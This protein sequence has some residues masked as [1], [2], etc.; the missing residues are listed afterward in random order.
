MN[1]LENEL[2]LSISKVNKDVFRSISIVQ[3]RKGD[4]FKLDK[5]SLPSKHFLFCE[6]KTEAEVEH[7]INGNT[8]K[9]SNAEAVFAQITRISNF[10][11]TI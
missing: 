2:S 1:R 8:L 7:V 4:C 6:K 3:P 11:R 9:P 5:F 10:W